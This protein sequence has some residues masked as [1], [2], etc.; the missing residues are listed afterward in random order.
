MTVERIWI[1][2]AIMIRHVDGDTTV[3]DIDQGMNHW[4]RDQYVRYAGINAPEMEG[5]SKTDGDAALAYLET[6][7]AT[8]QNLWLATIGYHEFEKYGRVLGV[9]YTAPPSS[10]PWA[11]AELAT[12]LPGSV[13]QEMLDAGHAVPYDPSNL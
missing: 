9:V 8:G 4:A 1:Y 2:E 11:G 10:I 5:P 3:M 6:L 13:N 12:I 7:I